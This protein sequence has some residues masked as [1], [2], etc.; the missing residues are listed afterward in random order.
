MLQHLGEHEAAQQ[1]EDA[2][3]VTLEQGEAV[4]LDVARQTGNVESSTSTSGFADTVIKNLGRA[5][6]VRYPT[7]SDGGP[8]VAP[9]PKPRWD[10]RPAIVETTELVGVDIFTE[11][12]ADA[13]TT[14]QALEV[15]AGPDFKL[16][17][18]SARGTLVYPTANANIDTVGWW[19]C[20]FVAADGGQ[21]SDAAILS[22]VERVG[23]VMPWVHIQ[24]L[25]LFEGA[26]GFTRAQGQ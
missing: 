23:A 12:D 25:R 8:A 11:H 26:E 7:K 15:V 1:I 24:K 9:L 6:S 16:Q 20:R 21:V 19:R 3:F 22:L 5:P 10:A 14:G 17:F 2:V 4:T 13:T 18:V